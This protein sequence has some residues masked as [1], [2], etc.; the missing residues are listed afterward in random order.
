MSSLR[1]QSR[2]IPKEIQLRP[3]TRDRRSASRFVSSH[4]GGA[5]IYSQPETRFDKGGVLAGSGCA[6]EGVFRIPVCLRPPPTPPNVWPQWLQCVGED[7]GSIGANGL[8]MLS[9]NPTIIPPDFSGVPV[10]LSGQ[11][12]M[13]LL[14]T[15]SQSFIYDLCLTNSQHDGK[16]TVIRDQFYNSRGGKWVFSIHFFRP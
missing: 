2:S 15:I 9:K 11:W 1:S 5:L 4:K 12:F 7:A 6:A 13:S 10:P 14:R 8:N 16:L 3:T